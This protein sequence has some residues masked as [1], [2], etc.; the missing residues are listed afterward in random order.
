MRDLNEF[1]CAESKVEDTGGDL[2]KQLLLSAC[3]SRVLQEHPEE[4][5]VE[6]VG[7]MLGDWAEQAESM[8]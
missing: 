2:V 5:S 7:Q 4:L 8:A 1:L 3:C 6:D